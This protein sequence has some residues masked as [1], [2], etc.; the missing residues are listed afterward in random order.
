MGRAEMRCSYQD[1]AA[2]SSSI[3]LVEGIMMNFFYSCLLETV[4]WTIQVEA[5]RRSGREWDIE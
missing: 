3:L 1:Y 2:N 4:S 5:I